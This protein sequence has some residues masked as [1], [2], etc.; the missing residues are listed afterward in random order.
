ME[1]NGSSKPGGEV[2]SLLAD[3][4]VS[5]LAGFD[6]MAPSPRPHPSPRPLLHPNT[7]TRPRV[8]PLDLVPRRGGEVVVPPLESPFQPPVFRSVQPV[9]V[10]LPASPSGFSAPIPVGGGGA[11]SDSD[12]DLRR[13][14]MANTAREPQH[15]PESRDKG[16]NGVRFVQPE[17]MMFRSQPIPCGQPSRTVTRGGGGG[18]AMS[19]DKRYDS[20]KTWSGKLERQLTHL[21]GVG[22]EAPAEKDGGDAIASHRTSSLPKVDR[23]FAALEGPE[24]DQLKSEEELVLPSDKTWPFLLRFPVS[25]FGICLGMGSQAILW[26]TIATSAPTTFLHV[27][28]KVNLVLWC[29]SVALMCVVSAIYGAKVVFF[30]EAVRREYYHPIRV[31]FFF[32]PWIACLFLVIG[33][34]ASVATTLPPWLWYALMAPVLCLELKIYGQWMSGGQRRLSKVA[35]PSNHLSVV[36]NFVGALLGASMGLR[37]GPVFFFAVGVAH[38]SV[39][40]VTLYQRLPT[41]ETLPK[42]LHPVFFLFVAAPSV[43]SMAWARITG[44]FGLGSRL[45]YFIAMFLYASLAVR[46]NFFRGF[47]FSLAWWAY[48]FPM[49]GA[50]IASIRYS[51]E[52]DNAF[53]KALCVALSVVAT[54]TVT[55]LFATTMVHAFVL[56]NLFPNDI[57]IA[58]TDGQ[59]MNPIKELHEMRSGDD[60]DNIESGVAKATA[61]MAADD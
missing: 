2:P 3:V 30:F 43:A 24:L 31:N 51:T 58:I 32:A 48:T 29:V 45:A 23:F 50:A 40:F 11:G 35:N 17:R 57:A 8:P 4:E 54:L 49:T 47:R 46:I 20:F 41:N 12:I 33:V 53:T 39:L 7:P 26:K 37:E 6:V 27:T 61:A 25:A 44:E 14:A 18:R 19:R 38:Y 13:Q 9:S 52:V 55:G 60:D 34:P 5:N 28:I 42:E 22:P 21:T 15:S 1:A 16:G 59:S 56:R 36:G 10:S